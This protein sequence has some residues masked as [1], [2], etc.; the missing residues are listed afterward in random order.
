MVVLAQDEARAFRHNYIGTEHLLLGVLRE[1]EGVGARVL[2]SLDVTLEEVRA[3]V[4]RIIGRGDE[5]TTGMIPFTPR[6]KKVLELAL[7]EAVK[8]GHTHIGTEH[9]LLGI[10]REK[11]GVAAR[12]LVDFDADA[13]KVRGEI[14]RTL[15]IP[16]PYLQPGEAPLEHLDVAPDF[17]AAIMRV[18][19]VK[20]HAIEQQ[21]FVRAAR[22]R[23]R[24]RRLVKLARAGD[25]DAFRRLAE[26]PL[27]ED[28]PE[29]E[30]PVAPAPPVPAVAVPVTAGWPLRAVAAGWLLFGVAL[31]LGLLIGWL[32]WG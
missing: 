26:T 6:A 21:S 22:L 24:E 32:V 17:E 2:D 27:P 4:A 15:S 23:D 12:I 8:L 5:E 19:R 31:G 30:P 13:D 9:I 25:A 28:A 10:V 1:E 14:L 18:R 16:R 7:R 11:E 3:Q 20:E 29:P